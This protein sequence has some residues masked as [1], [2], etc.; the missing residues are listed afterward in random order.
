MQIE[1]AESTPTTGRVPAQEC[2][3]ASASLALGLLTFLCTVPAGLAAI[4]TGLVALVKISESKGRL[5]GTSTA[6]GGIFLGG[7]LVVIQCALLLPRVQAARDS[8]RRLESMNNLKQLHVAVNTYVYSHSQERFPTDLADNNGEPLLSWRVAILPHLGHQD[9]YDRFKLDEP[10][11]SEHNKRLVADMPEIFQ[12]PGNGSSHAGA[13]GYLRPMG[14]GTIGA[15]PKGFLLA[16]IWDG[17]Q[18]TIS[19]VEADKSVIWTRPEDLQIDP[20]NP[21]QDL[22]NTRQSGFLAAFA[23]GSVQFIPSSATDE[24]VRALFTP[25]TREHVD[26]VRNL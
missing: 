2:K 12:V 19:I 9:L 13:T 21:R 23:D 7:T 4:A 3:W 25:S 6:I 15:D 20:A 10:W 5:T 1:N 16:N 24:D 17:A 11:N 18:N 26:L 8:A 22:G 14:K